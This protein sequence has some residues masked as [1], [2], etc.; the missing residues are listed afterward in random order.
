MSFRR[1]GCKSKAETAAVM[2][3]KKVDT[4]QHILNLKSN[5]LLK[6]RSAMDHSNKDWSKY[7]LSVL[8]NWGILWIFMGNKRTLL[9][10]VIEVLI[11][12]TATF[13]WMLNRFQRQSTNVSDDSG[14]Q[15]L[16][17]YDPVVFQGTLED[18][19]SAITAEQTFTQ[20]EEIM[21]FLNDFIQLETLGLTWIPLIGRY[22][23]HGKGKDMGVEAFLESG[24]P[25]KFVAVEI[26][27]G[28]QEERAVISSGIATVG[29]VRSY[30]VSTHPEKTRTEFCFSAL[31]AMARAKADE[32]GSDSNV[33]TGSWFVVVPTVGLSSVSTALEVA[34]TKCYP[35]QSAKSQLKDFF[36]LNPPT[37]LD[38]A[39]HTTSFTADQ[40]GQFAR[41]VGL[42]VS[43]IS[44][45]ML[46]TSF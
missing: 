6:A 43:L 19:E 40:M 28:L 44:F 36:D 12:E 37:H 42:E 32:I 8:K 10:N 17:S 46:R 15:R 22:A 16:I 5:P 35:S 2:W 4:I 21:T 41:A 31:E 20:T 13:L 45:G 38:P 7:K 39:H 27:D 29:R 26:R 9:L 34:R 3:L 25:S 30:F 11:V 24:R 14:I 1:L 18:G 23:S 33:G